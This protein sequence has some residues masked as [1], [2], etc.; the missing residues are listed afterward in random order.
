M[1][2]QERQNSGRD[3]YQPAPAV[4][5][6]SRN[7]AAPKNA[8]PLNRNRRNLLQ[9]TPDTFELDVPGAVGKSGLP[10]PSLGD[11]PGE[12]GSF[13]C[14]ISFSQANQQESGQ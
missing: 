14:I 7:S 5:T 3:V 8:A 12:A 1:L 10:E 6:A 2:W 11:W 4:S 13:A 9:P